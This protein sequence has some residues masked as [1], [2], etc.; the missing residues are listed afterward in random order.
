MHRQPAVAHAA[1][2][3]AIEMRLRDRGRSPSDRF[4]IDKSSRPYVMLIVAWLTHLMLSGIS[5]SNSSLAL[6]SDWIS[7]TMTSGLRMVW[8]APKAVWIAQSSQCC[9]HPRPASMSAK[10]R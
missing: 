8:V 9:V 1:R 3:P 6:S 5:A 4:I 10:G 2:H 7:S